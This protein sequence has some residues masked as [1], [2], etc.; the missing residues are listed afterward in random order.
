MPIEDEG[1]DK[2][3][4]VETA[5]EQVARHLD[6]MQETLNKFKRRVRERSGARKEGD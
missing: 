2:L 5:L 3:G 4:D 6:R 1:K